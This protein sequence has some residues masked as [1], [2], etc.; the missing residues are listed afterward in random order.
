MP[1]FSAYHDGTCRFVDPTRVRV[2]T[3]V[4]LPYL[5]RFISL[6]F[7]TTSSPSDYIRFSPAFLGLICRLGLRPHR[8]WTSIIAISSWFRGLRLVC[9]RLILGSAFRLPSHPSGVLLGLLPLRPCYE[10]AG[11]G[12]LRVLHFSLLSS[13]LPFFFTFFFLPSPLDTS[14]TQL[15]TE[16]YRPCSHTCHLSFN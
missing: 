6:A 2:D 16:R 12:Y 10:F 13:P 3:P 8:C 5:R 15:S 11:F 14:W 1:P 7:F 9:H 4:A